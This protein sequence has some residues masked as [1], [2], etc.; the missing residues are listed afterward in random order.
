MKI[1]NYKKSSDGLSFFLVLFAIFFIFFGIFY[2]SQLSN[3]DLFAILFSLF[4]FLLPSLFAIDIFLWRNYGKEEIIITDELITIYKKNRIFRKKKTIKLNTIK[5]ISIMDRSKLWTIQKMFEF[6]DFSYQG[7][8]KIKYKWC[9][10]YYFGE[11]MFLEDIEDLI[12]YINS[13]K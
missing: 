3:I 9:R 7:F 11:N 8:I 12:N 6:W 1:T 10:R 5:Q 2:I 13:K 4:F